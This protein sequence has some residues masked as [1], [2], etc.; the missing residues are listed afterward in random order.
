L[1]RFKQG[2]IFGYVVVLTADPLGDT[3]FLTRG[4]VDHYSNTRRPWIAQG[5]SIDVGD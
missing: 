1:Q 3:N 4:D 2:K 5:P